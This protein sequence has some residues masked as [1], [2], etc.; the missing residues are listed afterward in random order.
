M[1][2]TL[3][4]W[5]EFLGGIAVVLSLIYVAIQI[6]SSVK[7]ARVDSQTRITELWT[8]W[9]MV[10]AADNDAAKI[11]HKGAHDLESLT[12]DERIRF[13][14]I[15]SMYFGILETAYVHEL[16]GVGYSEEPHRRHRNSAYGV[17][18]LPGVY[19]WWQ[20]NR[21]RILSPSIEKYLFERLEADSEEGG[22]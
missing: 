7:L 9:A 18:K 3:A 8:H 6:R 15:T 1:L 12:L 16:A 21:G 11:F 20:V 22:T 4:N 2:E 19:A 14:Q 17:F 10:L 5:G 13:N